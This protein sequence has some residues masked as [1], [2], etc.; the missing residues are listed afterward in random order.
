MTA[1][2]LHGAGFR[3]DDRILLSDISLTV[4]QGRVTGILGP[5]GS[6]KSTLMRLMAGQIR[7][8]E[9][10][11]LF[12][13]RRVADH[14]ARDLA[15]HLAHLP[16]IPPAVPGMGLRDL[17]AL[18]R[19]P[20][21]GALGRFGASDHLAVEAALTRTGLAAFSDRQVDLLSGGERQRGWIAMLLAQG[22]DCLLL[23][24]PTSALDL[25][26]QIEVLGLLRRLNR[27][28]GLTVVMVLHDVN[29][30]A[31]FCDDLIALREGRLVDAASA[32]RVTQPDRLSELYGL[33][34]E[35]LAWRGRPVMMPSALFGE[36]A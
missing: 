35:A 27:E 34:M 9:G 36:D 10:E 28:Q 24:E 15:R 20:W 23:D 3:T 16:Q 11:V 22:A 30:A 21:H 26:H 29:L 18:G 1:F 19:Y 13:G 2:V 8:S 25:C 31:R 7:P 33:D 32:D 14:S 17:V 12:Q 4:R 6:G 5:N